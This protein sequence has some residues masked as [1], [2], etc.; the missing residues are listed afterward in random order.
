[1]PWTVWSVRALCEERFNIVGISHTL[2]SEKSDTGGGDESPCRASSSCGIVNGGAL[3]W[4][5]V[6]NQKEQKSTCRSREAKAEP[7][8]SRN[9][10]YMYTA[11]VC[12]LGSHLEAKSDCFSTCLG[13]FGL[14]KP[15][16]SLNI[17]GFSHTLLPEKKGTGGGGYPLTSRLLALQWRFERKV[18]TSD[19]Q[20]IIQRIMR[21]PSTVVIRVEDTVSQAKAP[22]EVRGLV[23]NGALATATV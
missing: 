13:P 1:M 2:L 3:R 10:K 5:L 18:W 6:S 14:S 22:K 15:I 19:R 17:S 8:W 16:T 12:D 9:S 20:R 7:H 11:Q 23:S 21:C 4:D